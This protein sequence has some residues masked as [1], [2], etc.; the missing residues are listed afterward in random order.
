V[1]SIDLSQDGRL[2]P[3]VD[4]LTSIG[5]DLWAAEEGFARIEPGLAGL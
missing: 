1:K 2:I 5:L 3:E 4:E